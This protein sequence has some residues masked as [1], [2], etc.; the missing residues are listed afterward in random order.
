MAKGDNVYL[1]QE[2]HSG[3]DYTVQPSG[4]LTVESR[5]M[6]WLNQGHYAFTWHTWKHSDLDLGRSFGKSFKAIGILWIRAWVRIGEMVQ[7]M[8]FGWGLTF[9][10][11]KS[12]I[13]D[14]YIISKSG[15]PTVTEIQSQGKDV[16]HQLPLV[17][18]SQT[19]LTTV[20]YELIF[21]SIYFIAKDLSI[22]CKHS[23]HTEHL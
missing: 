5:A 13:S 9:F 19:T 16:Y 18:H 7:V 6:L 15:C 20:D 4:C 2:W 8:L 11:W 10:I 12:S 3:S 23:K 1:F 14:F 17:S 21:C 22:K